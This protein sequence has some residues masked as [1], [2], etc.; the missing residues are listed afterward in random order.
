M[1]LEYICNDCGWKIPPNQYEEQS[2]IFCPK[3]G[4]HI[5]ENV[6]SK[7]IVVFT[8]KHTIRPSTVLLI[9]AT[10]IGFVGFSI[11]GK[12]GEDTG[13]AAASIITSPLSALIL[14]PFNQV[15]SLVLLRFWLSF[16]TTYK[17]TI[18]A[19]LWAATA[20]T[21]GWIVA[22]LTDS[23][24]IIWLIAIPCALLGMAWIYGHFLRD[25]EGGILGTR[26]GAKL[27]A[28]QLVPIFLFAV[29]AMLLGVASRLP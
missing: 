13:R 14:A 12:Y 19:H 11:E 18:F 3:C 23:E 4:G 25:Q 10:V 5:D 28:L 6:T 8:E 21:F 27:I 22:A 24:L 15:L 2:D 29:V 26:F 17:A 16:W 7:E 9:V 1:K 20:I